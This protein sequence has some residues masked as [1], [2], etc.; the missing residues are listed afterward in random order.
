MAPKLIMATHALEMIGFATFLN[1]M[2]RRA[3]YT[4]QPEYEVYARAYGVGL[5]DYVATLHLEARMV[6]GAEMYD[7]HA[8]G[9]S[10]EMAI[11]EL[12]RG[13][14]T[15]LHHEHHELWED[16]F[17]YLPVRGP[18]D[19]IAHVVSPPIGPFTLERCMAET[20]SAYEMAHRSL[21]WELNE[22]RSCLIHLQYQ[23]EPYLRSMKLPK[24]IMDHWPRHTPQEEAPPSHRFPH[25]VGTW[26]ETREMYN[27]ISMGLHMHR[28]HVKP[29]TRE[30]LLGAPKPFD[31]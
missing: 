19:P 20:I 30:S 21:V 2:L 3:H 9:T 31:P 14:I 11:Q 27:P 16:P 17:T 12:A 15:R 5:V 23:M 4:L 7:F 26:A 6:V 22:T 1:K 10:L 25:V 18:E 13:A 29:T 8:W 28:F 24:K